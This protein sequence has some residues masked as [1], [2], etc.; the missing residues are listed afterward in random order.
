[1]RG[2]VLQFVYSIRSHVVLMDHILSDMAF[3][4][5]IGLAVDDKGWDQSVFSYNQDRLNAADVGRRL[6]EEI[7]RQ[8]ASKGLLSNDNLSVDGTLLESLASI[9][10]FRRKNGE[11]SNKPAGD[12]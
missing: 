4:W 3:R 1:M 9:K 2:Q 10:S 6:L 7:T 11:D 8:A 12:F 5:F